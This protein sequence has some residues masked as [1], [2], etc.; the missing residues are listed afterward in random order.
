MSM[1]FSTF[2]EWIDTCVECGFNPADVTEDN[3]TYEFRKDG[4]L[5]AYW[6]RKLKLG[7]I[8]QEVHS[9]V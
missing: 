9:L 4:D 8:S 1:K 6:D 2:K 3:N 5:L 7:A